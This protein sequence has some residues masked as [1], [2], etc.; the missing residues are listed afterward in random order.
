MLLQFIPTPKQNLSNPL[1]LPEF[2]IN[3]VAGTG[4]EPAISRSEQT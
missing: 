1:R 2:F 3:L 4:F